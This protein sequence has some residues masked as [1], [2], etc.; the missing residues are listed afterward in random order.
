MAGEI[1]YIPP[2]R[3]LMLSP[4]GTYQLP[5]AMLN[6]RLHIYPDWYDCSR[7]Y[8]TKLV[9][10]WGGYVNS[11]ARSFKA[12]WSEPF[13]QEPDRSSTSHRVFEVVP[14]VLVIRRTLFGDESAKGEFN[15]FVKL[16][17]EVWGV[18]FKYNEYEDLAYAICPSDAAPYGMNGDKTYDHAVKGS[19]CF[20]TKIVCT[21]E[22]STAG[23]NGW[24]KKLMLK[25]GIKTCYVACEA[26]PEGLRYCREYYLMTM[27]PEK[28]KGLWPY[29]AG[30]T[31]SFCVRGL[32][33]YTETRSVDLDA[34][35]TGDSVNISNLEIRYNAL[36]LTNKMM[37]TSYSQYVQYVKLSKSQSYNGTRLVWGDGNLPSSPPILDSATTKGKL[38]RKLAVRSLAD[39]LS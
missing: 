30:K 6:K 14:A 13:E 3:S 20:C 39:S 23:Y 29:D 17:G 25:K 26:D 10:T 7:E 28:E 2:A 12:A 27:R 11:S 37:P 1:G 19:I 4:R 33:I 36:L 5:L 9:K 35:E 15:N 22:N 38:T 21:D 8:A 34:L 31:Y 24:L 32:R 16:A 18:E